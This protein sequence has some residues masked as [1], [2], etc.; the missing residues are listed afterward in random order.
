M[1]S[2]GLSVKHG[3]CKEFSNWLS[4]YL[5]SI[6]VKGKEKDSCDALFATFCYRFGK[7]K[8]GI[9]S[10]PYFRFLLEQKKVSR[11][12]VASENNGIWV[13]DWIR[14]IQI[15][16]FLFYGSFL[17]LS[18]CYFTKKNQM[19]VRWKRMKQKEFLLCFLKNPETAVTIVLI[20]NLHKYNHI[21]VRY[22]SIVEKTFDEMK[23]RSDSENN[24][25]KKKN[26]STNRS[27]WY[28]HL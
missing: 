25:S 10:F 23:I 8:N 16:N 28:N 24:Y 9:L 11:R 15:V 26:C 12:P 6:E 3:L 27:Q 17:L 14:W 13:W 5:N 18:V 20:S 4:N 1:W 7:V 19:G 22:E 2:H 21:I